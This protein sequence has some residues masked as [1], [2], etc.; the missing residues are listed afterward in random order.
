M[1]FGS[2]SFQRLFVFKKLNILFSFQL[3]ISALIVI[4]HLPLLP[5]ADTSELLVTFPLKFGNY[6][7]Q[8]PNS[9]TAL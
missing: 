8:N 7:H 3:F 9:E 1:A 5:C 4:S 6:H 2:L